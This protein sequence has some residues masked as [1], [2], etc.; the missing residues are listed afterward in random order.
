MVVRIQFQELD[1]GCQKGWE[2]MMGANSGLAW[3]GFIVWDEVD[4]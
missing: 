2:A 4:V 3:N 1:G